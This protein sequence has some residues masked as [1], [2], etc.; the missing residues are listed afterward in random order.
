MIE[1]VSALA[2]GIIGFALVIGVGI[3]VLTKFGDTQAQCTTSGFTYNTTLGLC[4]NS[5]G[6]TASA[7]GDGY[8]S[9]SYL[10]T[11]LGTSGLA[12]WT[13]AIV[14]VVIGALFL[15]MFMGKKAGY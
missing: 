5:T 6:S 9:I 7:T 13:P 10:N 3:V 4:R 2:Y 15:A 8:T 12:S 1:N 11:Q 14:A